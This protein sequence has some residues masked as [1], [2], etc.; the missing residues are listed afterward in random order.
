MNKSLRSLFLPCLLLAGA[1]SYEGGVKLPGVY[2]VDIQ[3]GNVVDQQ[4]L[5]R[6]EPG[7]DKY[8][9]QFILGTPAIVDP[10][11]TDQW[12]YLF[13]LSEDG[14][15]RRQR[16]IRVHFE[17][18]RLAWVD[19]DVETSAREDRGP[20]RQAR[21]VD[22]PLR[23]EPGFFEKLINAI[24]FV[25]DTNPEEPGTTSTDTSAVPASPDTTDTSA[26]PQ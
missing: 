16:H 13:T 15:T 1:C 9:V 4:M 18:G 11:H 21:T 6:L 19:G 17:D 26:V 5:D 23:E 7:M 24:P 3:Q 2:R 12:E 22:V 10:F 14:D 8:Q 20:G 25:G